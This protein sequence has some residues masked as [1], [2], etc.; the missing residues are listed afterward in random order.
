MTLGLSDER[1]VVEHVTTGTLADELVL[2]GSYD[3]IVLDVMLPEKDGFSPCE[4]WR[5]RGLTVP[6]LFVTARDAVSQ[7]VRGLDSVAMTIL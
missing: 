1:F 7:R 2:T 5:K 3:L 4:G 6:I